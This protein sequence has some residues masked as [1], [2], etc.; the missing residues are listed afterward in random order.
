MHNSLQYRV[1]NL[2][3]KQSKNKATWVQQYMKSAHL[4]KSTVYARINGD[5]P[6]TFEEGISL[7]AR[8][9]LT[10]EDIFNTQQPLP[11]HTVARASS[12]Q[13]AVN[14]FLEHLLNDLTTLSRAPNAF[15]C[16]QTDDLP[17]FLLKHVRELAGFKLFHWQ[18]NYDEQSTDKQSRFGV[19]WTHAAPV[20][21]QLDLCRTILDTYSTVPGIEC[22]SVNMFSKTLNQMAMIQELDAYEDE[23]VLPRLGTELLHLIDILEKMAI[24]GNKHPDGAGARLD[25]FDNRI[26]S[27]GF[28]LGT[29]QSTNFAYIN[30]TSP[31]F[32]RT[33]DA[34]WITRLNHLVSLSTPRLAFVTG[35]EVGRVRF[36]QSLRSAVRQQLERITAL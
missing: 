16:H 22:W 24:R 4:A 7:M 33:D 2:I 30:G 13:T 26:F 34:H 9:G 14:A 15:T 11:E 21:H 23:D 31:V 27:E 28:L 32:I 10:L 36:F 5:K 3:I 18:R 8:Y 20:K 12:S 6:I 1:F 17:F 25:I 29:S 19:K 35:S